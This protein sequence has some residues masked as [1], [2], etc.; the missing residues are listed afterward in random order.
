[1]TPTRTTRSHGRSYGI[2][3]AG[4]LSTVVALVSS[5][6]DRALF[7]ILASGSIFLALAFSSLSMDFILRRFMRASGPTREPASAGGSQ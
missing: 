6:L 2:V 7:Y 5:R 1:M 4:L 3:S